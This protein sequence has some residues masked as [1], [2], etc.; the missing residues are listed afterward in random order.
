MDALLVG[1]P[2]HLEHALGVTRHSPGWRAAL[3]GQMQAF[4]TVAGWPL[5]FLTGHAHGADDG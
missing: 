2:P 3:A 5:A 1:T 4:T